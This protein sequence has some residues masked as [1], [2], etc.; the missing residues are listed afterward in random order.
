MEASKVLCVLSIAHLPI[1]LLASAQV[2]YGSREVGSVND[3]HNCSFTW[4][5]WNE[6]FEEC[7]CG[8]ADGGWI[9]CNQAKRVV[10]LYII[11]CVYD[12]R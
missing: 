5:F 1:G 8:P 11:I 4:C 2:H 3:K 6:T 12:V 9:K 7:E 10:Q